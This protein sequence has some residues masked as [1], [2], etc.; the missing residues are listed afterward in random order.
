M[1]G[2]E[3]QLPV[4][5]MNIGGLHGAGAPAF[6]FAQAARPSSISRQIDRI[7]FPHPDVRQ[8]PGIAARAD[9]IT[10]RAVPTR[11]VPDPDS[12]SA[13]RRSGRIGCRAE[14]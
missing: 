14:E 12:E 6:W 9:P 8:A 11:G 13:A 10:E 7:A 1:G 3:T 4:G 5:S 2:W